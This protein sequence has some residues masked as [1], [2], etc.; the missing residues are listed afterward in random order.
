MLYKNDNDFLKDI[1]LA[2][3]FDLASSERILMEAVLG[4][5]DCAKDGGKEFFTK[6]HCVLLSNPY[7][8]VKYS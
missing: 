7:R 4:I 3:T 1:E 8:I 6:M 5:D 2:L